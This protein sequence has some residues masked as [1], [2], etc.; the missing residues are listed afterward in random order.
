MKKIILTLMAAMV[1]SV[2]MS[3][4][5]SGSECPA[6]SSVNTIVEVG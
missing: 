4:C 1:I 6:Y 2:A 3:A 5:T